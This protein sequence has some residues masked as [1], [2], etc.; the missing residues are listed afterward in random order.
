MISR[1]CGLLRTLFSKVRGERCEKVSEFWLPFF[2]VF[3]Q[4]TELS[5][6]LRVSFI[7]ILDRLVKFSGFNEKSSHYKYSYIV[8]W[9]DSWLA[10]EID[11]MINADANHLFVIHV[12]N[13]YDNKFHNCLCSSSVFLFFSFFSISCLVMAFD[14]LSSLFNPLPNN[15]F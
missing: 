4:F 8:I 1:N 10:F 14:N 6:I 5:L 2:F 15:K 7:R 9:L 12:E 3:F 11:H 13:V